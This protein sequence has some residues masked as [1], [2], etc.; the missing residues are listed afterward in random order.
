[1]KSQDVIL[2]YS[3]NNTEK[4]FTF[5]LGF[6]T[7]YIKLLKQGWMVINMYSM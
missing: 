4:I 3:Q 6:L 1:M 5:K 7:K 2:F